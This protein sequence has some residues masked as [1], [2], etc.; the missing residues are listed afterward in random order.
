SVP[1]T[2]DEAAEAERHARHP[3]H[4]A[5]EAVE[6]A[7]QR[8]TEGTG[9]VDSLRQDAVRE[10]QQL[11]SAA[12]EI[13]AASEKLDA[14]RAE[15]DDSVLANTVEEALAHIQRWENELVSAEYVLR[16]HN[17]DELEIRLTNARSVRERLETQ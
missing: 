6:A 17:P 1:A 3:R 13:Q 14:A 10:E 11:A 16:S 7:T 4:E 12:A 8:A 5:A 9:A 15:A 2:I